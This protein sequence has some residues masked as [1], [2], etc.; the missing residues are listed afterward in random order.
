MAG[1]VCEES[2]CAYFGLSSDRLR[3]VK[4]SVKVN[5]KHKGHSIAPVNPDR[6]GG[7]FI[8]LM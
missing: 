5:I 7:Q 4:K 8:G 3:L 2:A 1:K 6:A